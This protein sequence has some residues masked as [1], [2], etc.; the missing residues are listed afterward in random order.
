MTDKIRFRG[1]RHSVAAVWAAFMVCTGPGALADTPKAAA[2]LAPTEQFAALPM[3][4]QMTLSPDGE[5][6]A[7]LMSDG[8]ST[9]LMT[10]ATTGNGAPRSLLGTDNREYHFNWIRWVNNDRIVVS[11]RFASH[12]NFVGTT[13][14]RLLSIKAE[15]GGVVGLVHA[16]RVA[17][18]M[19]GATVVRQIQDRV[20]DWLPNDGQHLLLELAESGSAMPA[21]FR[22]N[23]NTGQRT[24]VKAPERNVE[25]WVTDAQGRVRAAVRRD[26]GT[27]EVRVAGVDG[28]TWRT[29]WT[30]RR[31]EPG[32]WPIG[33]GLDPDELYIRADHDG[34]R[35][36]FS[37]RLDD[38]TLRRTLR[39]AHP[40][41]DAR[42][43]LL[44]SPATGEVIGLRRSA[45][46]DEGGN[47]RAELWDAA[48]RVQMQ[49][50]D[51]G[52]PQ[53]D[54]ILL[55]ISRDE[56]RYLIH[57]ENSRQPGEFYLGD[58]KTGKV[59]LLGGTYPQ[60]DVTLLSGKHRLSIKARDGLA[61]DSYLTLPKGRTMGD[62][63]ALLPMVLLPHG[64]PHS[65]DDAGFDIWT[66][67]LA[68]RGYAVLQVNF[69]GSDG[70]GHQFRAAGL[71]RWGLEMQ[72]DLTD[73][74]AWAIAQRVADPSRVCIVGASYGGYAALMGAVKTP[75]LYRCAVSFAGVSD[76][77]DL[78]AH[79]RDYIG[80]N[81]WSEQMIGRVWGDRDRLRA[82]SP[83]RQAGHIRV[84]VLLVHGTQ[85][86]RVPVEQS[87]TM[88]RALRNAGKS[89]RYIEQEGGDHHLSRYEHRL[90]FFKALESFLDEHLGAGS[91]PV[92][93]RTP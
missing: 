45:E 53:R 4:S 9:H 33:F 49:G 32:V 1:L 38:P 30:Y 19:R 17:G 77:P 87:E 8:G 26:D 14:T 92:A 60:L 6:L 52:L 50:V 16:E 74:V 48:W 28:K 78:V 71:K 36:V 85:D 72:D 39:F 47:A 67:F 2:A 25:H 37:V 56:Q 81:E 55:G 66:E 62:G 43:A 88:A 58:R 69:R 61:L 22:V 79:L 18:S 90:E 3:L 57:S 41:E 65:A 27:S 34:R 64:G 54:N 51:A 42:G 24:I 91:A 20:I 84:P 82:T 73:G 93:T 13:E 83:A 15:G 59:S 35:A 63:G 80:G 89:H 11:L 7:F 10:R 86:R 29:L 5:T 70:Y 12:R 75:D 46:Q 44:R 23:V 21:V 68:N 31:G 40:E 76:L